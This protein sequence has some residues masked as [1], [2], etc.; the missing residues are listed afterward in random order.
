MGQSFPSS[1]LTMIK[2]CLL[3]LSVLCVSSAPGFSDYL[4]YLPPALKDFVEDTIEDG[5]ETLGELQENVE[6]EVLAK[7]LNIMKKSQRKWEKPSMSSMVLWRRTT[8]Y[9]RS[10]TSPRPNRQSWTRS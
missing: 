6:K 8:K 4:D 5:T 2:L 9:G 7:P 10:T 3:S 1:H